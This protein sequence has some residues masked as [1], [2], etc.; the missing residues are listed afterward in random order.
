MAAT[1]ATAGAARRIEW[2]APAPAHPAAGLAR[3]P[4]RFEANQGQADRQVRYTARAAGSTLFL[5]DDALVLATGQA[6]VRMALTGAHRPRA[7][8]HLP[9]VS[10]YFVGDRSTWAKG[11]AGYRAVRYTG[12]HPGIDLV[13]H[14]PS[15]ALEYDFEVDAGADPSAIALHVTGADS[16]TVDGK[17]DLVLATGA[18]TIVQHRPVAYQR[19]G[20]GARRPVDASFAVDGRR[21]GFRLGAYDHAR[22]L[23]IDPTL[24]YSTFLGG[25]GEDEAKAVAVDSAG[26]AYVTG[27]TAAPDF[28][29]KPAQPQNA[30]SVAFVSKLSPDGSSLVYSTYFGGTGGDAGNAVAVRDG[31]AWVAGSTSSTDFPTTTGAFSRTCGIDGACAGGADGFLTTFTA[32]GAIAYSSYLGGRGDDQVQGLAVDGGGRALLTGST[33]SPS[34][35]TT[36]GSFEPRCGW[37]GA[38]Y[39]NATFNDGVATQGSTTYTS[40]GA[41]FTGDDA[42]KEITGAGIPPATTIAAVS[43]GSTITLSQPATADGTGL[44]FSILNAT[45]TDGAATG[46]STTFH[47]VLP[48]FTAGDA[49][50]PITG[51]GI[52]DG[53]TVAAYVDPTTLTLSAP[54]TLSGSR[55]TFA[56]ARATFADGASAIGTPHY[57]SATAAFSGSDVGLPFTGD[58]IPD[59]TTVA[60]VYDATTVRL[61]ANPTADGTGLTFTVDRNTFPGFAQAGST[62]F[63]NFART[64]QAGDVGKGISGDRIPA[65]TTIVAVA[66][67]GFSATLSQP[68]TSQGSTTFTIA[69]NTFADGATTTGSATLTSATAAFTAAD[70]GKGVSGAGIPPSTTIATVG[71]ATTVTLSAPA[72]ATA[73]GVTFTVARTTFSDGVATTAAPPFTSATA[74]F[75]PS[76]EGRAITGPTLDEGTTIVSVNSPT[77]VQLS[78]NAAADGTG[79]AFTVDRGR[80]LSDPRQFAFLAALTPAGGGGADLSYST[81]LG[82]FGDTAGRGVAVSGGNAVVVGSTSAADLPAGAVQGSLAGETDA[83]VARL[84]T[85]GSGGADL[86]SS[87]FLGGGRTDAANAVTADATGI[88]VTGS[89]NSTDFPVQAAYDSTFCDS[90]NDG[91]S[92]FV[93][94]LAPDNGSLVYSTYLGGT[95]DGS[96]DAGL[97][98]AVDSTGAATVAGYTTS[99]NFPTVHPVLNWRGDHDAFVT[100]LAANGA[101][102]SYSTYLG[103]GGWDQANGVGLTAAGDAV[104]AGST[105]PNGQFAAADF[106]ATAGAFDTLCGPA[107][108]CE[109]FGVSDA[110]VARLGSGDLSLIG[111]VSPPGG[112]ITVATPVLLAGDGFTGATAVRFGGVPATFTVLSDKLIRALSPVR[113]APALVPV[114][115]TTAAGTSLV[116]GA[117]QFRYGEG[118]FSPTAPCTVFQCGQGAALLANGKVLVAVG[119]GDGPAELYDPVTGTWS[120]TGSCAD[121]PGPGGARSCGKG[122][123]IMPMTTLSGPPASCGANCGKVLVAGGLAGNT[124]NDP[125]SKAAFL[126]DP[127]S[128]TWRRTADMN[129]ARWN[130]SQTLLPDGTVLVAGGCQLRLRGC[131]PS[132]GQPSTTA[133]IFHPDTETWTPTGEMS[134]ARADHPAV[135]LDPAVGPCGTLCG[136]VLAIGGVSNGAQLAGVEAYDPTTHAW[137]VR[138]PLQLARYAEPALQVPGGVVAVGGYNSQRTTSEAMDPA[139]SRWSDTGPMAVESDNEGKA[140]RLPNGKVLSIAGSG[141]EAQLYDGAS[142]TFTATGPGP[143]WFGHMNAVVLPAGPASACGTNCGKVLIAGLRQNGNDTDTAA[144]LYTPRP[145]VTGVTAASGSTAGGATVTVTGTGLTTVATVTF[146]EVAGTNVA[147]DPDLPDTRLTVTVP[148]H[149]A[150]GV[151]VTV[152]GPAGRSP[153]V[154]AGRFS[155]VTPATGDTTTVAGEP[156]PARQGYALVGADGAVFPF[157]AEANAGSLLGT[158]LNR[159]VMA[160]EHSPTGRGYWLVGSDGGVFAFGDAAFRGSTGAMRLSMPIVAVRSTPSGNGYWLVGSDGGVFAFG[161]ARFLGSTG[162]RRLNAPVVA[163]ERTPKGDGYWLFAADGGVFSFGSAAFLGSTGNLRLA[164]PMVG[165]AGTAGGGGYSMVA[166]DGGVFAFG[167][168]AFRGSAVP[169]HPVAPVVG[170]A[171]TPSGGGYWLCG[172]DG[173]VFAFGDAQFLGSMGSALL[174]RP[175]VA[176]G[177]PR[178]SGS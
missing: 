136:K 130:H 122:F 73:T 35:P 124:Q 47:S 31:A 63:Y 126:Y 101:S 103:G 79:L 111:S 133:E 40:A 174:R 17:G 65:G 129:V 69:R 56:V 12:V 113:D 52:P 156:G 64:F 152:T 142:R 163:M 51:D 161:D 30:G 18:G 135:L 50:H 134:F 146:G 34:F 5:T 89:T 118:L 61:S 28:P 145:T 105:G 46:G 166:A 154:A 78:P 117:T 108:S 9:G 100:R 172:S 84:A 82:G 98:V 139:T 173:G 144:E 72:T 93:T 104:V 80:H 53:T 81:Y 23:V 102:L 62:T 55:L 158:A 170:M 37:D 112:P 83:F 121:L 25:E 165:A 38:C 97:A 90:C 54:A 33:R 138:A 95:A 94:K 125:S 167:D 86:L 3:L 176:C 6:T 1:L 75:A 128:G 148:A 24:S 115:V 15:G 150:G 14:A 20:T 13:V 7:T 29:T 116:S 60:A 39:A 21:V 32:G 16:L 48:H 57:R 68:A 109:P 151:D 67:G 123:P 11:I 131:G 141:P 153:V 96:F 114:T 44:V 107:G 159:P 70:A 177:A 43:D 74:A 119:E 76:D 160:V 106:P 4:V 49:G 41:G 22:P 164:R 155:F 71:T 59:G 45:F 110:F 168:A 147:H 149:A 120:P 66:A 169:F 19:D 92:A 127:V 10:N 77:S 27:R 91:Q 8:G 99:P 137:S 175:V 85:A 132:G 171:A 2:P 157:G 88:Y 87:T 36:P 143:H 162:D 178:G 42:G 58:G 140:V 26:N